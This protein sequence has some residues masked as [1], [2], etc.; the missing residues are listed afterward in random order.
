[1]RRGRFW[2]VSGALAVVALVAV[3]LVVNHDGGSSGRRG[4][5]EQAA[6][7]RVHGAELAAEVVTPRAAAHAPLV[8][9]P[10]SWGQ[11]ATEYREIA[12]TFAAAGY[13]VV[14]YAQRG[15]AP[16]T[17]QV[18]FAGPETQQDVSAVIDWALA[19]TKA[20]R[21]RIGLFGISYG[22]GISLLAAARDPRVRA[23]AALSTWTDQG[24]SFD[25]HGTPSTAALGTLVGGSRSDAVFG[26]A[27]QQLQH[28]LRTDPARAGTAVLRIS[29]ARSPST[30]VDRLNRNRPAVLI[31]NGYQDSI[32]P[33]D[34]LVDFYTA[35]RTP[36]RLQL[37]AGDHGG[38]ELG[39]LGGHDNETVDDA[40]AW[41]DHYL[42]GVKN[43]IETEGPIVLRDI[44]TGALRSYARWPAAK[45]DD[46]VDLAPP[47][48]PAGPVASPVWLASITAGKDSGA[49]SGRAQYL[50]PKGYQPAQADLKDLKKGTAFVWEGPTLPSGV[51]IAG[52][53]RLHVG[54]ASTSP[55][56]TVF[57][58]LYDVTPD[59][60]GNLIT[61]TPYSVSG[62][63]ATSAK[64]VTIPLQ[65]TSWSVPS[66]DH[67]ALVVDT[68]DARY[69]SLT[70]PGATVTVTSTAADRATL[71]TPTATGS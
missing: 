42:R 22:A 13:Q 47:G 40:R 3:L 4:A 5:A 1:M 61:M 26:P 30:Y 29:A 6:T 19:H 10:A 48:R 36:K 60:T 59:G 21:K 27:V 24:A 41:F 65:P 63:R 70:T 8:V 16:S 46:E 68:V 64:A 52:T 57:A 23:V 53:P 15:F 67:V 62:L 25:V 11:P 32:F 51:S 66:G 71:T 2:L 17:G 9:M 45:A 56:T 37:A 35:L 31:A 43:R 69:K 14:A 38:P 18:D 54:L 12:R 39:A 33:P 58:Y 20:D 50:S 7:I 55:T 49:A 34:Q 44:H 28:V